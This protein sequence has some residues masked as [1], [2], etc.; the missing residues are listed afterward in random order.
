VEAIQGV[1]HMMAATILTHRTKRDRLRAEEAGELRRLVI[2]HPGLPEHARSQIVAAIDRETASETRWTF[3]MLSAS[4]NRA[5]VSWL[6]ENSSRPHKAV[7]LWAL[8]F[9]HLRR[10]TGEIALTREELAAEI[11]VTPDHISGL[12]RELERVGAISRRHER[13]P[14]LRGRGRVVYFMNPRVGTHLSGAARDR[15]QAEA[16]PLRL[17]EPAE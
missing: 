14:G 10:D 16:P 12:M 1:L 13:V 4:Q 17:V 8:C 9:E 5:V 2:E 15:A 3:V 7:E 11:G 6:L